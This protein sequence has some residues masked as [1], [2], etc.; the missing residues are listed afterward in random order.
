MIGKIESDDGPTYLSPVKD[1]PSTTKCPQGDDGPTYLSPVK[2]LPSTTECPQGN[3]YVEEDVPSTTKYPPECLEEVEDELYSSSTDD[4]N[5]DSDEYDEYGYDESDDDYVGSESQSQ[6]DDESESDDDYVDGE[7]DVVPESV[8]KKRKRIEEGSL[9]KMEAVGVHQVNFE[10]MS[11][12]TQSEQLLSEERNK[13]EKMGKQAV[14]M[15]DDYQT[16]Q[17]NYYPTTKNL[18]GSALQST[19]AGPYEGWFRVDTDASIKKWKKGGYGAIARDFKGDVR[20]AAAGSSG[21]SM[22]YNL[23]KGVKLGLEIAKNHG[24]DRIELTTNYLFIYR[25]ITFQY[26]LCEDGD[27]IVKPVIDE[28]RSLMENDIEDVQVLY[29]TRAANKAADHLSKLFKEVEGEIE[30][31]EFDKKLKKIIYDDA[32]CALS[33]CAEPK[34]DKN[35][36]LDELF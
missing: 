6:S 5:D 23:V 4:S 20:A 27:I 33:I 8:L 34:R 10:T 11:T 12:I 17:D 29:T 3:V 9:A 22:V 19:W 25:L 30:P 18:S 26:E 32:A 13:G 16:L 7:S 31:H 2:D 24:L 1:L 15:E 28:I 35:F 36:D 14:T 21:R